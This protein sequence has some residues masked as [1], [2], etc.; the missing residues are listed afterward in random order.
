MP[1]GC[2]ALLLGSFPSS[3][4]LFG[5]P[6]FAVAE[7]GK[8]TKSSPRS[9]RLRTNRQEGR[10]LIHCATFDTMNGL[11]GDVTEHC[12]GGDPRSPVSAYSASRV[13]SSG[14]AFASPSFGERTGNGTYALRDVLTDESVIVPARRRF[15]GPGHQSGHPAR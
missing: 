5:F 14:R 15:P 2:V 8:R 4:R 10:F 6:Y 9:R 7:I 12:C 11:P 13:Q 1:S 3:S